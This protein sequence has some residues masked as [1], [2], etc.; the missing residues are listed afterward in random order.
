MNEYTVVWSGSQTRDGHT[1]G[2]LLPAYDGP[3]SWPDNW[4][5]I[6]LTQW[7]DAALRAMLRMGAYHRKSRF[8]MERQAA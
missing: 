3:G 2:E 6:P 7:P 8:G 4:P 5:I 1:K